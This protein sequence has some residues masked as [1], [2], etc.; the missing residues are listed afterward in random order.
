MEEKETLTPKGVEI[1]ANAHIRVD[2]RD[3][4]EN[5]TVES[6][7]R[8]KSYFSKKYG[9]PA[10]AVKINF[11]PIIKNK[12]GKE[13]DI[14]EGLIEN[15]MNTEYQRN[16]FK[17]WIKR[18]DITVDFDRICKLD[19]QIN[20][21][22]FE[23]E[24][25]DYRF[26]RWDIKKIWIDNFL[27]YGNGNT[28]D[29][30]NLDGFVVVTSDPPNQGGKTVFS[31]DSLL[32]LFF[33]KTTKTDKAEEIFNT[34]TDKN[35]VTVGGEITIDGEDYI[36]ER[37]IKRKEKKSGG[38]TTSSSLDFYRIMADGNRE[39]LE[40]EQRRETDKL[41]TETIGSYDDFMTTIVATADNLSDLIETKPT[42]RGRLLTKFIGL[43]PIEKKE[44]INKKM[45]A[46]FKSKM[47]SNIYNLKDLEEGIQDRKES[48]AEQQKLSE[49]YEKDITTKETEITTATEKK[50][51]LLS[52]KVEVDESITN[53][54]P[55]TL[56]DDIDSLTQTGIKTKKELDTVTDELKEIGEV[57]FDEDAYKSLNS[58]KIELKLEIGKVETTIETL[59]KQIK[60]MTEGE[61]CSLCKQPLKDVDHSAQIE[62]NTKLKIENE[63]LLNIKN[64]NL[65]EIDV[66]LSKFE[67][68][69]QKSDTKD[70]KSLIK[71]RLELDI[72]RLRLDVKEK[73]GILKEYE[74]NVNA[75]E[76][77]RELDSKILG[78]NQ[79]ITNLNTEK[80]KLKDNLSAAKGSIEISEK[81]I[82]EN[83][84][85]IETIKK[86]NEVLKIFDVYHRMIGKNG[87]SKL[88]LSSV[89]PVINYELQRLLDDV[90]DFEL[91]LEINDKNEVEFLIIKSGIPK[92][93][94][95]GSGLESTVSS[96]ALRC[97]L[98]RISTLP[99][100]NVIVFDEVLGKVANVNLDYVK[101]FFDKI[102]DMYDTI[103]FITHN[104]I[105]QDWADKI[106]TVNKKDDIS[107]LNVS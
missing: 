76:K 94:K 19:D 50:E 25:E 92:K 60:E 105:A 36:I 88:V 3:Y 9:V 30:E 62:E 22:L 18:N 31:I 68:E 44:D 97:I 56:N 53:I 107:S 79:L 87:I 33:G 32:F 89:I 34:Y 55:K 85:L 74:S 10:T 84:M 96:L 42:Q 26:R 71:D 93:L 59:G 13:I 46:D 58:D 11:I 80:D 90:V 102:K 95:S 78:Y 101:L 69:K 61:F 1:P 49:Q 15:I 6:K 4:P 21:I 99:K 43:E 57:N 17:E 14:S 72:D 20:E 51:S 24:K 83:K 82:E 28:L 77:N 27:S 5:R 37:K 98:G 40:G 66:K 16:L 103:L 65:L 45:M 39:N 81:S 52:Q 2:W 47:K 86:E 75:I 8:V 23:N 35:E 100:P 73:K 7:N 48:I 63:D 41:I 70:K 67:A 12:E 54:N 106:I 38:Y 91:E 64:E 104:P 29:Y